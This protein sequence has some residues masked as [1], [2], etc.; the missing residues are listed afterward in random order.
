MAAGQH[1]QQE[2]LPAAY[3]KMGV[4]PGGRNQLAGMSLILRQ[5]LKAGESNKNHLTVGARVEGAITYGTG[6]SQ[7]R[8]KRVPIT[9]AG[10]E[11]QEDGRKYH[12]VG[13]CP[14]RDPVHLGL[15]V[16]LDGENHRDSVPVDRV[17]AG[18]VNPKMGQISVVEERVWV[19][20]VGLAQ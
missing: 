18:V 1:L 13:G 12:E 7:R 6:E 2:D 11:K 10:K 17:K 3:P 20:G 15:E 19:L 4:S 5:H 8:V 9:L 14:H 16:T